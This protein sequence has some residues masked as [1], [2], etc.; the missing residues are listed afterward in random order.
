MKDSRPPGGPDTLRVRRRRTSV[1]TALVAGLVLPILAAPATP[2]AAADRPPVQPLPANLEAIRAAEATALYGSP[3]IRPLD[4]RRTALITM[5]DSEISGEGVG[6]YV[7]GTHQNGNWCDRSYDQAVFRTGIASDVQ[8]NIACSGA[9]PWNLVAG[10]PTQWNELNQGDHLAIKAR[11]TRIKLIWVVVGA[12]GDGT[13]QFGPV[14]TDC[15]IRRVFFQG[16]CY[17]TYTDQ[18][19]IRTDGSRRGAEEALNSIRQTMTGAG[20]LRSD[21]ELVLMSYPSPGSPDVEDNPNFP[22]W[23][24]GGCLLYLHDVA[25]ARNKAVPLFE[26]A[27]RAAAANTGTRYLDA[28]RLFHGREVCTESPAVRGLYIEVGIWNENAARQSFHPNSRGHGLFAQCITQFYASG[29]E[30]A[31]CVDEAG[32]GNGVLHPGLLEFR[33]LRNAG[34]GNCLDGKGYDSRNGTPQ[35]P[36]TCHGGRNQGFWYDAD[37]QSVHSELSHDRCLDVSGGTL[38]A[39]AAVNIYDCHGGANQRFVFAGDQIK[40]AGNA[41]LCLAFDNPILGSARLRLANCGSSARQRWSFESRS[42]ANPVGYGS[43]DFIG[44]RVY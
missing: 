33:Q 18:W 3:T 23:Y 30:R 10:G 17:P 9:T 6:N 1:V 14:A 13:I 34:T 42:Y 5:G 7:P 12:N 11:N 8:Y 29:Q 2:A 19:T 21:Y 24:S 31:T 20:Y 36:Y 4:Q 41:N 16:P 15:A 25:F 35:Q 32:T 43:D 22:G 39:N 38:R 28:S 40:P 44:S 37:R 26:S 27:L